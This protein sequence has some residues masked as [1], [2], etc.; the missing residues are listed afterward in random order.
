M[1]IC[2]SN[3]PN[4]ASAIWRLGNIQLDPNNSQPFFKE[5]FHNKDFNPGVEKY[6]PVLEK[7][8]V[9]SSSGFILP[10]GLSYVDF[11]L[12][13]FLEEIKKI[14]GEVFAKYPKLLEYMDKFNALPQLKEYLTKRGK[15]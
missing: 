15:Q 2:S 3:P 11:S 4:W 14:E 8:L 6:F 7:I 13:H 9:Q 10:S 12:A 5:E 1:Y